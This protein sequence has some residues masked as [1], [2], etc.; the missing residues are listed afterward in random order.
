MT[1]EIIIPPGYPVKP[2]RERVRRVRVPRLRPVPSRVVAAAQRELEYSD[3]FAMRCFKANKPYPQEWR[4]RDDELR[5]LVLRSR[6]LY[7]QLKH[8]LPERPERP[9]GV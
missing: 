7:D 1:D 4:E 3:Q 8:K 2:L 6:Y 9:T 5:A